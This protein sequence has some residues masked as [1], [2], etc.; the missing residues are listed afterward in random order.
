MR[1]YKIP[2][3]YRN[4]LYTFFSTGTIVGLSIVRLR[5]ITSHYS[6]AEIGEIFITI[7]FF[8]LL[9]SFI[10]LKTGDILYAW[11]DK[12]QVISDKIKL[13]KCAV[14][15]INMV[16]ILTI[17]IVVISANWLQN[18]LYKISTYYNLFLVYLPFAVSQLFSSTLVALLR[19]NQ[20][21]LNLAIINIIASI[22]SM[23]FI[24]FAV[25]YGKEAVLIGIGIQQFINVF[26]MFIIS[27]R[28][29]IR[30]PVFVSWNEINHWEYRRDVI[31]TL[32]ASQVSSFLKVVN[33]NSLPSII[34]F[35]I[36]SQAAGIY[37]VLLQVMRPLFMGVDMFS[38][39]L[40]SEMS[41]SY[42]RDTSSIFAKRYFKLYVGITLIVS[43]ILIIILALSDT[44]FEMFFSSSDWDEVSVL[45][46][47][48]VWVFI[49]KFSGVITYA[50]PMLKLDLNYRNL[51]LFLR[52]FIVLISLFVS[53][54]LKGVIL[55]LLA[56]EFIF[57][58]FHDLPILRDLKRQIY[59][60]K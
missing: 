21:F 60:Q 6:P 8:N 59:D 37:S 42:N 13:I 39:T 43:L 2:N 27:Y 40:T 56:S 24:Y 36:G 58:I 29:R 3:L 22:S 45:F 31:K 47:I 46:S 12:F 1:N 14:L 41:L 16:A 35:T 9:F 53:T 23:I 19:L 32:G 48:V 55:G 28:M 26:L 7:A 15:A 51:R 30:V 4:L 34:G 57:W 54:S 5:I 38:A 11:H 49:F 52:A 50:I 25:D 18:H 20:K 17:L 10:G 44:V 33:I